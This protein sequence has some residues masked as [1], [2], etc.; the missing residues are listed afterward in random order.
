MTSS[1]EYLHRAV[2]NEIGEQG[3][4]KGCVENGGI[5]CSGDVENQFTIGPHLNTR[6]NIVSGT[7][8]YPT[9]ILCTFLF[10]SLQGGFRKV[11]SFGRGYSVVCAW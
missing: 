9:N 2:W 5:F 8:R 11:D 3:G 4:D 10:L 1:Y 6:L 7:S